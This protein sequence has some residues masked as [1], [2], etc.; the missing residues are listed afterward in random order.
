[1]GRGNSVRVVAK[2]ARTDGPGPP[3]C[4]VQAKDLP[5]VPEGAKS[6]VEFVGGFFLGEGSYHIDLAV[7][8]QRG[9]LSRKRLDITAA[10]KGRERQVRL[11][12][13]PGSIHTVDGLS[14]KARPSRASGEPRRVTVLFHVASLY[15]PRSVLSLSDQGQLLSSLTSVLSEG[16][17]DEVRLVAFNLDQQRELFRRDPFR[18]EDF[19]GLAETLP[20]VNRATIPVAALEQGPHHLG[21][22]ESLVRDEMSSERRPAA[23]V[24]LG[25]YTDEETKWRNLPCGSNRAG[26]PLFYFQ[27]RVN[28]ARTVCL[29]D[30]IACQGDAM[31]LSAR[32]TEARD[33]LEHLVRGCS[34]EVYRIHNPVELDAAIKK[35]NTHFR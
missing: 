4:F 2:I 17:F 26:P 3:I 25:P 1:V 33:T 10:R 22:L 20:S 28:V 8:D 11:S 18:V 35:L 13:V 15:G 5:A 21:F 19:R 6:E 23:I 9:R 7:S 27:H 24:F 31:W 34:G 16:A 32:P 29:Q 14:W 12:L 30:V